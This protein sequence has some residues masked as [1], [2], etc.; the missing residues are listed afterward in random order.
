APAGTFTVDDLVDLH[1]TGTGAFG[2]DVDAAE[3]SVTIV[4]P[5]GSGG[6]DIIELRGQE[7]I[8][9]ALGLGSNFARF[10]AEMNVTMDDFDYA[11]EATYSGGTITL[12][13]DE[14]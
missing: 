7:G 12:R 11:T 1:F 13:Q 5:N 3:V 4:L 9:S 6:F 10:D 8:S 2:G 14:I